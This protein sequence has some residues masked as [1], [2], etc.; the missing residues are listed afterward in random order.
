MGASLIAREMEKS[1]K[2]RADISDILESI[3]EEEDWYYSA[4]MRLEGHRIKKEG[5]ELME[6]RKTL[7]TATKVSKNNCDQEFEKINREQRKIIEEK[8]S[9]LD[10]LINS[11]RRKA[12]EQAELRIQEL[13][14]LK[15]EKTLAFAAVERG[16]ASAE[17]AQAIKAH[18][19]EIAGLDKSI[20]NERERQIQKVEQ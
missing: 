12:M 1:L 5:T 3:T 16:L 17:K 6:E 8:S 13:Q 15:S 11:E 20:A 10:D 7:E 19:A 14:K 2:L 18:R 9:A 4:E